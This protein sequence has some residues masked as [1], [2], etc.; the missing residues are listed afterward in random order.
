M[1]VTFQFRL[2]QL[3][4]GQMALNLKFGAPFCLAVVRILSVSIQM[5]VM[6]IFYQRSL[7]E[8]QSSFKFDSSEEDRSNAT[9]SFSSSSVTEKSV[10]LLKN[11]NEK[12]TLKVK[13]SDLVFLPMIG[14]LR[15]NDGNSN[16]NV[17]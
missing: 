7:P 2:T 14:S 16:E 4:G 13:R 15:G 8:S 9:S 1:L 12:N 17:T 10:R 3:R 11:S 5:R 6:A